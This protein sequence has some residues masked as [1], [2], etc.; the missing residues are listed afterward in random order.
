MRDTAISADGLLIHYEVEGEGMP[1]LV[2]IH[3][4]SCDHSYWQKQMEYFA[5]RYTVAAIDLGGHGN[6]GLN[7]DAWT[8]PAFGEDVVA[9]VEKLRLTQDVDCSSKPSYAIPWTFPHEPPAHR[10][11]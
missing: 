6:S 2:F 1:A 8:T 3:G 9:V 11:L 5:P 7:R 4:W 10:R